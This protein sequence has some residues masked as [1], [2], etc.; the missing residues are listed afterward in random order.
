[1]HTIENRYGD[2]VLWQ[3]PT[4]DL[5]A[6][7]D[8]ETPVGDLIESA[9][10]A[11]LWLALGWHDIKQRYRRSVVGPFWITISTLLFLAVM[12][13]LYAAL[14][15]QPYS[16]FLP[17]ATAGLVTGG[18]ISGCLTE[19]ARVF[20][21]QSTAIKQ[22]PLPLPVHVFRLLWLQFVVMLHNAVVI[23]PIS[24]FM[25]QAPN[26]NII[27][28][29]PALALLLINLCWMALLLG[30]ISARYRDVPIIVG[31]LM[32]IMFLATPI[33]WTR[34]LL[35]GDRSWVVEFN[36]IANMIEVVRGPVL[37]T[38]PPSTAWIAC[39][40]AAILGWTVTI[41]VY[42]RCRHRIASWV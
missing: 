1:V 6:D 26:H 8:N 21:D 11:P 42:G 30:I 12:S 4:A 41:T 7:E 39:I 23:V 35:P 20:I 24:F 16:V 5:D 27:L 36:P 2:G 19:G 3:S 32:P 40:L 34:D 15:K 38:A 18:F 9:R 28:I 17:M 29:L 31:A 14:F 37:G 13:F 22:L 33:F 10:L 25:G